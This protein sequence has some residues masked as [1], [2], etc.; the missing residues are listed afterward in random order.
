MCV[1]AGVRGKTKSE[2]DVES[3]DSLNGQVASGFH[4]Y[5]GL[6]AKY[7]SSDCTIHLGAKTSAANISCPIATSATIDGFT[8]LQIAESLWSSQIDECTVALGT[9]LSVGDT[10]QVYD[11]N[12]GCGLSESGGTCSTTISIDPDV[13]PGDTQEITVVSDVYCSGVD[14]VVEYVTL[15]FSS[16]GLYVGAI[17]GAGE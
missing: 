10:Q 12:L 16:C 8:T 15:Q 14:I 17:S 4:F 3:L 7:D 13:D 6:Q 5:Q 1:E 2:C 9:K 11:I